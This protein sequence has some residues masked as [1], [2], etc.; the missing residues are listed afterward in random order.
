MGDN[1]ERID[2]SEY[3]EERFIEEFEKPGLPVVIK[4]ITEEWKASEEWTIEV[5]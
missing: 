4:G 1:L 5:S 3:S 2:Q